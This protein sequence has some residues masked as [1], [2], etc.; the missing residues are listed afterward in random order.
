MLHTCDLKRALHEKGLELPSDLRVLELCNANQAFQVMQQE[1]GM[2]IALPC[3][4][5]IWQLDGQTHIGMLRPKALLQMLSKNPA[6]GTIAD[7][8]ERQMVAMVD[9]AR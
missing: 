5:S 8:V 9:A 3:R 2:N 1:I 6:L 7:E 4:I